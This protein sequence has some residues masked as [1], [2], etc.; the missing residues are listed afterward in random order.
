MPGCRCLNCKNTFQTDHVSTSSLGVCPTCKTGLRLYRCFSCMKVFGIPVHTNVRSCP[1]CF[2][3]IRSDAPLPFR[4]VVQNGPPPPPKRPQQ[5]QQL[6]LVQDSTPS[7][8]FVTEEQP[9]IQELTFI[10][11]ES[12]D[13]DLQYGLYE[14][15]REW[16]LEFIIDKFKLDLS[17]VK[18]LLLP[19]NAGMASFAVTQGGGGIYVKFSDKLKVTTWTEKV[20]ESNCP[21]PER[22]VAGKCLLM[23]KRVGLLKGSD[24]LRDCWILWHEFG[25]ALG[26]K[27][28]AGYDL[29]EPEA[30]RFE[31]LAV[32]EAVRQGVF[33]RWGIANQMVKEFLTMRKNAYVDTPKKEKTVEVVRK[34]CQE[35][36]SM[37]ED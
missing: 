37:L 18:L 6:L 35:L 34:L 2:T 11:L 14:A 29:S 17:E 27:P 21:N 8:V 26:E 25:H 9:Q 22:L 32:I 24:L 30:W 1:Y 12:D 23:F 28:R 13:Y 15:F 4:K 33:K 31:L 19:S 36:E 16:I 3:I 5:S 20:K 7:I 10:T